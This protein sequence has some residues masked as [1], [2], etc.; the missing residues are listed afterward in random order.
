LRRLFTGASKPPLRNIFNKGTDSDRRET[1]LIVNGGHYM[2]RGH[3]I[4][5]MLYIKDVPDVKNYFGTGRGPF[6]VCK[7]TPAEGVFAPAS[8]DEFLR[9]LESVAAAIQARC[10]LFN[11]STPCM[12]DPFYPRPLP[13]PEPAGPFRSRRKEKK[14]RLDIHDHI[15]YI[16]FILRVRRPFRRRTGSKRSSKP[17]VGMV[18]AFTAIFSARLCLRRGGRLGLDIVPGRC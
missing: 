12:S 13:A 5:R 6:R 9:N 3:V 16:G 15:V 1:S 8:I 2:T 4:V 17:V 18:I 7:R 10:V 11:T 14:P